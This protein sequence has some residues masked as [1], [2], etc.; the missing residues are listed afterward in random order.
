MDKNLDWT[1]R[2]PRNE[3]VRFLDDQD[4]LLQ[5]GRVFSQGNGYVHFLVEPDSAII[6]RLKFSND[7]TIKSCSTLKS[8]PGKLSLMDYENNTYDLSANSN[9]DE[10]SKRLLRFEPSPEYQT[11]D[12]GTTHDT[13]LLSWSE[14]FHFQSL[15][16]T[17]VPIL[18]GIV[19]AIWMDWTVSPIAALLA[20][21]G[22]VLLHIASNIHN[23]I[24]DYHQALINGLTIENNPVNQLPA[25]PFSIWFTALVLYGLACLAGLP[26]VYWRGGTFLAL[27]FLAF[28]IASYYSLFRETGNT[29]I[30]RDFLMFVLMGPLMA[31]AASL[32]ASGTYDWKL[33]LVSLPVGLFVALYLHEQKIYNIPIDKR[34]GA[35]TLA[36]VLGF[37]GSKLYYL[38][39]ILMGYFGIG[40]L[41]F[42]DLIPKWTLLSFL[43]LPLALW[44][45]NLL[46]NVDSPFNPE[47]KRLRYSTVVLHSTFGFFYVAGFVTEICL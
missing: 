26:L 1:E 39:L 12:K 11:L 10:R 20:M 28:L 3:R 31:T 2:F 34:A 13:N 27:G 15:S 45:L 17:I 42:L 46:R 29:A 43:S 37:N 47:I 5:R 41:S 23:E 32:A 30:L 25:S 40:V 6:E 24:A 21:L 7:I 14:L 16:A 35:T 4:D 36:V 44:N 18:L 22:G 9:T 33:F 38:I 8:I 19:Y